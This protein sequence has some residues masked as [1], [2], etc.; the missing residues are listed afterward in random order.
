MT[1]KIDVNNNKACLS[2]NF[3]QRENITNSNSTQHDYII[4]DLSDINQNYNHSNCLTAATKPDLEY[5]Q[6]A[7]TTD[8][9]ITGNNKSANSQTIAQESDE[10]AYH[11]GIVVEA[12][13]NGIVIWNRI[14]DL[15]RAPGVELAK[16]VAIYF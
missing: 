4:N 3:T 13:A 16:R 14:H 1:D 5:L 7:P 8:A 10:M 11:I 15:V 9:N 6:K 2:T 12:D